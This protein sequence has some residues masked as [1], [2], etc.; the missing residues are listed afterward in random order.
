[1]TLL[2]T[3]WKLILLLIVLVTA[4]VFAVK[5]FFAEPSQ[6]RQELILM[7]LIQAVELAESLYGSKTGSIK[8]SFVYKMFIERFGI[9]GSLVSQKVFESLVDKALGIVEETLRKSLEDTQNKN[10]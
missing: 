1:M 2:L 6:K 9:L 4:I 10:K 8:L 5:R 7:W 3:N